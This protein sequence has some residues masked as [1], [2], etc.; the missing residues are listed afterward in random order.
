MAWMR[1]SRWF[2]LLRGVLPAAT[3]MLLGLAAV[4]GAVLLFPDTAAPVVAGGTSVTV[5]QP[6]GARTDRIVFA[7]SRVN[8]ATAAADPRG[9]EIDLTVLDL[10]AS[11][12]A[13]TTV[14]ILIEMPAGVKFLRCGPLQQIPNAS[15]QADIGV[16]SEL[17]VLAIAPAVTYKTGAGQAAVRLRLA[18]TSPPPNAAAGNGRAVAIL[19]RITGQTPGADTLVTPTRRSTKARRS[20]TTGRVGC[21]MSDVPP[22]NGHGH[23]HMPT[24]ARRRSPPQGRTLPTRPTPTTGSFSPV[25]SPALP[26]RLSSP[27]CNTYIG[28]SDAYMPLRRPVTHVCRSRPLRQ[29]RNIRKVPD[30]TPTHLYARRPHL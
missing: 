2:A 25:R 7:Q 29:S 27:W 5:V 20:P 21:L 6:R 18:V 30:D 9:T 11:A 13:H 10:L 23:S 14:P 24:Q 4:V 3:Y 8:A 15:C 26:A 12:P 1:L 16:P 17:A 22:G 28:T 19:P